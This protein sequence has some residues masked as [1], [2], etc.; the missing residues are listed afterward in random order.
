MLANSSQNIDC[1]CLMVW[2]CRAGARRQN[3]I[4]CSVALYNPIFL[5]LNLMIK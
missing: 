4:H 3:R 1:L 5:A 2:L